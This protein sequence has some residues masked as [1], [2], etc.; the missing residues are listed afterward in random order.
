MKSLIQATIVASSLAASIAF[1]QTNAPKTRAEVRAELVQ[2]EKSG[3]NPAARDDATYPADLQ[4]AEVRVAA[5][6]EETNA[7]RPPVA[8]ASGNGGVVSGT[9]QSS[10]RHTASIDGMK[11]TYFGQ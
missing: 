6:N 3:Y 7:A 5:Q 2:L 1:A 10:A 11:P 4:A 8:D 9:T